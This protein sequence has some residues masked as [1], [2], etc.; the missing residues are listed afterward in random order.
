MARGDARRRVGESTQDGE[1]ARSY[2]GQVK[3]SGNWEN[4]LRTALKKTV[5][6]S[7]EIEPGDELEVWEDPEAGEIIISKV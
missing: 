4:G 5:A 7:Q 3:V 1:A 2:H 6:K